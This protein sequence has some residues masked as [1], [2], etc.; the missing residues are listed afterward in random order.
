MSP[1][2][3]PTSSVAGVNVIP[4]LILVLDDESNALNAALPNDLAGGA[5]NKQAVEL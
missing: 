5:F 2:P 3:M 1:P 4:E